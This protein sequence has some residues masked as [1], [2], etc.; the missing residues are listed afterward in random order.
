MP[1]RRTVGPGRVIVGP[2]ISSDRNPNVVFAERRGVLAGRSAL[3]V[4]WLLLSFPR[5]RR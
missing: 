3:Y 5:P 4:L 2:K 1:S